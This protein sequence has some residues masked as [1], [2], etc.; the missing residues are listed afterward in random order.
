MSI[1]TDQEIISAFQDRHP[2]DSERLF[3]ATFS[4][5]DGAA[6]HV[7]ATSK[8]KAKTACIEYSMRINQKIGRFYSIQEVEIIKEKNG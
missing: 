6:V 4:S 5:E 7:I 1:L 3:V 8:A 2:N